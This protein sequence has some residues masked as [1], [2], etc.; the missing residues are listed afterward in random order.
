MVQKHYRL[1]NLMIF[2]ILLQLFVHAPYDCDYYCVQETDDN[3]LLGPGSQTQLKF[4]HILIIIT[5]AII[6]MIAAV[7]YKTCHWAIGTRTVSNKWIKGEAIEVVE[8]FPGLIWLELFEVKCGVW[9]TTAAA[10]FQWIIAQIN[11]MYGAHACI[12]KVCHHR[13]G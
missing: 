5:I 9:P 11:K 13:F 12:H 10:W 8:N 7:S 4:T 2:T 6:V 1:D 3:E